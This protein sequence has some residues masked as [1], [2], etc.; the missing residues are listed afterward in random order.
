MLLVS[1]STTTECKCVGESPSKV[2]AAKIAFENRIYTIDGEHISEDSIDQ[3]V[4]KVEKIVNEIKGNGHAKRYT[5][6][7]N[8]KAGTKIYSIKDVDK[9]TVVAVKIGDTFYT[10]FFAEKLGQ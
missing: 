9:D 7:V 8:L 6:K 1:C 5:S 4:G 2:L 10:A 3:E